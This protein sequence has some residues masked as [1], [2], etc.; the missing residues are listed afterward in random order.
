LRAAIYVRVS[1]DEQVQ[2]FSIDAQ[3]KA[4]HEL[5]KAKGWDVA[6][7]YTDAGYSARSDKRPDFKRMIADAQDHKFDVIIVHKFDRF[8][9]NRA[10]AVNYKKIL[11]ALGVKVFS[12]SEPLDPDDP[13]GVITEG[14]LEVMA[15]WYSINLS[16]ETQKGKRARA[17]AG[18]Q[19]NAIPFGYVKDKGKGAIA[20]IDPEKIKGYHLAVK[21]A[22]EGETD[23]HIAYALNLE[24]YRTTKGRPFS[25]D[26]IA[27]MLQSRFYLGEVSYHRRQW[28]KGKHEAAIDLA[29]WERIQT[30]RQARAVRPNKSNLATRVFPLTT[31]LYCASC[32]SGMR[33]AGAAIRYY[34]D[35]GKDRG[36]ICDQCMVNAEMLEDQFADF[37]ADLR[38]PDDWRAK[39]I[40]MLG[41]DS[42]EVQRIGAQRRK[43]EGE[44]KRAK[45]LFIAGDLT[46]SE[47]NQE[48]YRITTSMSNLVMPSLPDLDQAAALLG[49]NFREVWRVATNEERK[50]L[51][52]VLV[53]R[54][55]VKGKRIEAIEPRAGAYYV[56]ANAESKSPVGSA[57]EQNL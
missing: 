7:I 36:I 29:T 43:L 51:V 31:V 8:A 26:T 54:A 9:R 56:L 41:S 17:E 19:N 33:G 24:T 34:R 30:K 13:S 50:K 21:L 3:L 27:A 57:N 1:S 14:M 32:G 42:N 45:H 53:A 6:V 47:F 40:A 22:L 12:V 46:E 4:C 28:H 37:I 5:A 55:W 20:Q 16:C 49:S 44:M 11:R 52:S 2:G 25:K 18:Y 48:K 38:L 35:T 39:A 10:D 23:R 15:E